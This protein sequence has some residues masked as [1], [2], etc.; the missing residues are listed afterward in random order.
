MIL[1]S[2][3]LPCSTGEFGIGRNTTAT[4]SKKKLQSSVQA[5]LDEFPQCANEIDAI[6]I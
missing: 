1:R 6:H 4:F 2:S 3:Y 5:S